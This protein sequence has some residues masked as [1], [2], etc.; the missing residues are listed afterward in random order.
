MNIKI[1]ADKLELWRS[2]RAHG[3]AKEMMSANPGEVGK[4]DV[5]RAF[6]NGHCRKSLYGI[7]DKFYAKK[8]KISGGV[9]RN[10]GDVVEI[11]LD[12]TTLPV[13]KQVVQFQLQGE[14]GDV[15]RTGDYLETSQLFYVTEDE[16]YSIRDVV[17]WR[18][19]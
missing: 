13:N 12:K 8:Q 18:V 17:R 11:Q 14:E 4:N 9:K 15:W 5:T 2:L 19:I 7:M 10:A 1:P 6:Q 3:D 16:F